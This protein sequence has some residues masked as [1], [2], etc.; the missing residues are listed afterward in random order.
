MKRMLIAAAVVAGMTI[1][2]SSAMAQGR[3]YGGP[4]GVYRAPVAVQ[5]GRRPYYRGVQPQFRS[6]RGGYYRGPNVY[7]NRGYYRGPGVYRGPGFYNRPGIGLRGPG[8]SFG[9]GF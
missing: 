5:V 8:I 6:Y 7:R 9:I 4:R 3:Y 2:T 1:A